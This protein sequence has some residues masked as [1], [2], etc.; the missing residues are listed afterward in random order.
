[1]SHLH[2]VDPAQY[3]DVI[4][5]FATGVCVVTVEGP[6]GP[7]GM[8]A[9]AVT[10][11]SLDPL[12]L[13]VCFAN[14]ARTLPLVRDQQRFGVNILAAGQDVLAARFASKTPERQKFAGVAHRLHDGV[15]V[16]DGALGWLGCDLVELVPAGDHVIAIGAVRLAEAAE[17]DPL[18]WYRGGYGEFTAIPRP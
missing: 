16:L 17:G 18:V 10:S 2:T 7:A 13:L 9:N 11:V 6:E 4:G 12:L 15:P 1:M 8:T 3:R 14:G 5:R